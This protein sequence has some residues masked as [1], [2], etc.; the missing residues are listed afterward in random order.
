MGTIISRTQALKSVKNSNQ[1]YATAHA[2]PRFERH[3][4]KLVKMGLLV[5]VY[6]GVYSL[7]ENVEAAKAQIAQ[8]LP[9]MATQQPL[10]ESLQML[11]SEDH[12]LAVTC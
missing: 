5:E 2:Q 3:F 7:P 4:K 10:S 11:D 6:A 9:R 12:G 8:V 1:P